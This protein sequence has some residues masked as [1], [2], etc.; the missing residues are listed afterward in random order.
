[1]AGADCA[2]ARRATLR[3]SREVGSHFAPVERITVIINPKLLLAFNA[4]SSTVKI[5]RAM[6]KHGLTEIHA[7]SGAGRSHQVVPLD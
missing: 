4:G 3:G 6:A 1:M 7:F 5:G 2:F